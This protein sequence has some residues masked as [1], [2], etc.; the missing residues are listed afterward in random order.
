M[1]PG[2][3]GSGMC[4]LGYFYQ[5][6]PHRAVL[7]LRVSAQGAEQLPGLGVDMPEPQSLLGALAQAALCPHTY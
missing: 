1:V 7:W 5:P 6:C 3:E 4:R 2:C